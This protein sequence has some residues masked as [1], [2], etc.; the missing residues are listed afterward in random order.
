MAIAMQSVDDMVEVTTLMRMEKSTSAEV[1]A[2]PRWPAPLTT[3]AIMVL[4]IKMSTSS[5]TRYEKAGKN[6]R[7]VE[8]FCAPDTRLD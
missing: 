6:P 8:R 4:T 2:D 3:I 5:V 7:P 1:R